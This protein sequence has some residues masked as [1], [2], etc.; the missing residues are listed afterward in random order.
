MFK[1]DCIWNAIQFKRKFN[2]GDIWCTSRVMV[3]QKG[4]KLERGTSSEEVV[5][6]AFR[7]TLLPQNFWVKRVRLTLV[8][9]VSCFSFLFSN[10]SSSPLSHCA[11]RAL[12]YHDGNTAMT[13]P[14]CH[15]DDEFPFAQIKNLPWTFCLIGNA[16]GVKNPGWFLLA[17]LGRQFGYCFLNAITFLIEDGYCRVVLDCIFLSYSQ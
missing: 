14:P 5:L 2:T 16:Y 3:P 1:L 9:C 8:V 10:Q 13:W 6:S 15:C 12:H 7:K 11:G 4:L 17:I